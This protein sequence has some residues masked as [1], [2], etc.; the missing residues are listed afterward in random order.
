ML[1][2]A[3]STAS[4]TADGIAMIIEKRMALAIR[5]KVCFRSFSATALDNAGIREEDREL[6]TATGILNSR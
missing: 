5:F 1:I 2:G 6:A 3:A 4:P